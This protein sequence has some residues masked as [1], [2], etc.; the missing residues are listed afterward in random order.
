M[1]RVKIKEDFAKWARPPHR[2]WLLKTDYSGIK[3]IYKD[4]IFL[5]KDYNESQ[6]SVVLMY[7]DDDVLFFKENHYLLSSKDFVVI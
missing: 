5:V 4:R 2:H 6:H 3:D 7:V 1:L